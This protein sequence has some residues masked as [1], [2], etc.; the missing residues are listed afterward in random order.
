MLTDM[1]SEQVNDLTSAHLMEAIKS[2]K[3][4]FHTEINCM[5]RAIKDIQANI[6]EC[7]GRITQA[8]ERVSAAEDSIN[9]LQTKV[10]VLEGKDYIKAELAQYLNFN[11]T[12][13]IKL[14]W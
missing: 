7:N 13:N 6:S 5:L 14:I 12:R 3:Q 8:E 11:D 10:K 1:D 9:S 2:L 4:D